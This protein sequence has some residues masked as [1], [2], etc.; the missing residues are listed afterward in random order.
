[1]NAGPWRTTAILIAA[2]LAHPTYSQQHAPAHL[3][4]FTNP[5]GAFRFSYPSDFSICTAGKTE[6]CAQEGLSA[7]MDDAIVCV[8]YPPEKFLN[9]DFEAASFE[10]REIRT[11]QEMMTP[12]VCVTPPQRGDPDFRFYWPPFLISAEQPTKVIGGVLFVHG[13]TGE[14]AMSHSSTVDI[15]RAFH[16]GRCFELSVDQSGINTE[17]SDPPIKQLTIAQL[18]EIGDAFDQILNSFRFLK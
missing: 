10:V 2:I 12:D 18:N 11:K 8:V 9:T 16:G 1:M 15:Y 17:G 4:V 3:T 14:V 6:P 7:C 5:D 13:S